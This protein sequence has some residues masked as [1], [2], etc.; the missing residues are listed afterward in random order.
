[1]PCKLRHSYT[2][3]FHFYINDISLL[4]FYVGVSLYVIINCYKAKDVFV[5]C[6]IKQK[7]V[8]NKL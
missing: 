5:I 6:K 2:F 8:I 3:V 1:M 4:F 7:E